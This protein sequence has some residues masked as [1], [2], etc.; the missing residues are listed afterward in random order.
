LDRKLKD[1]A[2]H[3]SGGEAYLVVV[4]FKDRLPSWASVASLARAEAKL[5][6]LSGDEALQNEIRGEKECRAMVQA[7]GAIPGF[8]YNRKR[9]EQNR[10]VR[11]YGPTLKA[12]KAKIAK[13]SK[14]YADTRAFKEAE[15]LYNEVMPTKP[16]K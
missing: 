12:A 2:G 6:E 11:R 15:A 1:P 16:E 8:P 9:T 5:K 3:R 4:G 7:L 10:W 13:L 14:K